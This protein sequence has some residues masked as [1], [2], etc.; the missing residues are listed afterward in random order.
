MERLQLSRARKVMAS[1]VG[2]ASYRYC[3]LRKKRATGPEQPIA[4]RFAWYA[5]ASGEMGASQKDEWRIARARALWTR[6]IAEVAA[7]VKPFR[8]CTLRAS[9]QFHALLRA[10]RRARLRLP[11]H[12]SS[13]EGRRAGINEPRRKRDGN[14]A[15]HTHTHTHT[16]DTR[17][18]PL[19]APTFRR[20]MF[21][22]PFNFVSHHARRENCR[23]LRND[24]LPPVFAECFA[25]LFFPLNCI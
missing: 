22:T 10:R 15:T 16:R 9:A 4:P 21:R 5:I 2:E 24:A 19:C 12:G 17:N 8:T 6:S 3:W 14:F 11:I 18:S 20:P 1:P 23:V 13:E 7:L 25:S